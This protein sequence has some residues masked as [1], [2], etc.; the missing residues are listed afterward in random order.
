M[1]GHLPYD[2]LEF[3]GAYSKRRSENLLKA[4]TLTKREMAQA[5]RDAHGGLSLA[6]SHELADA[7]LVAIEEGLL[8]DGKVKVRGFGTF[9][10]RRRRRRTTR[11]PVTTEP[12]EVPELVT[13][14][15]RQGGDFFSR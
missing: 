5:L 13:V 12:V 7:I 2:V 3:F 9:E 4:E 8:A 15:F 14:R 11:H 10:L 1:P 6:E